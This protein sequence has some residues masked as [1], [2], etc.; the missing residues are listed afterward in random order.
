MAMGGRDCFFVLFSVEFRC[1]RSLCILCWNG[2]DLSH[3]LVFLFKMF[4]EWFEDPIGKNGANSVVRDVGTVSLKSG[5]WIDLVRLSFDVLG[6]VF[7]IFRRQ[8]VLLCLPRW[9]PSTLRLTNGLYSC[10]IPS[11]RFGAKR[12]WSGIMSRQPAY[13]SNT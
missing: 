1:K 9:P 10:N 4:R 11:L 13:H 12:S 6:R 8:A 2:I 5:G 7:S 3:C